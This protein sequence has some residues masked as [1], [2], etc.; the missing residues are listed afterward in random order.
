MEE[1][2]AGKK[3]VIPTIYQ[4]LRL[5]ISPDSGLCSAFIPMAITAVLALRRESCV[6]GMSIPVLRQLQ[7]PWQIVVFVIQAVC[8]QA[9]QQFLPLR[10]YPCGRLQHAP[11]QF[12]RVVSLTLLVPG[13]HPRRLEVEDIVRRDLRVR[14]AELRCVDLILEV[15]LDDL[16]QGKMDMV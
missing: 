4:R 16:V 5:I 13:A 7:E 10:L 15:A 9:D 3:M 12:C 14:K 8:C 6:H 11:Q 2:S 1:G